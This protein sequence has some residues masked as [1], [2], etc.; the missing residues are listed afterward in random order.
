MTHELDK[1]YYEKAWAN[2]RRLNADLLA[3]S[4]RPAKF[5]TYKDELSLGEGDGLIRIHRLAG[6]GHSDDLA[7]I[8]LPKQKIAI[9]ADA[10]SPPAADAPSPKAPNPYAVNLYENIQKLG[11]DVEKIAGLHGARVA[12]LD[13]LR[14]Y[15]GQKQAAK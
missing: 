6:S 2:P 15:I 5:E 9:E 1:P 12:S 4:Q 14:A 7:L 10:Y 13:D 8:Y 11:L 3:A